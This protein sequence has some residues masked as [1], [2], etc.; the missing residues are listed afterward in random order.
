MMPYPAT[1]GKRGKS[2]GGEG[3]H[4]LGLAMMR[5]SQQAAKSYC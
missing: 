4:S 5:W 2:L 3:L 1:S